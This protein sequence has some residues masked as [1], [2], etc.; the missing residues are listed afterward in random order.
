M[1]IDKKNSPVWYRVV[2]WIVL[3]AFVV[4]M[5]VV[6]VVSIFN[7]GLQNPTNSS[8]TNAS[9]QETTATAAAQKAEATI[10]GRHQPQVTAALAALKSKPDDFTTNS[11]VGTA[12]SLW[13]QDLMNAGD[14]QS[15]I[16][17]M[18]RY[19]DAAPYLAKAYNL[20]PTDTAIANSYILALAY[21]G[22]QAQATSVARDVTK[23]NPNDAQSWSNLGFLLSTSSDKNAKTEAIAALQTAIKKDTSG[24]LKA[25]AQ[26]E[27][28]TL[29]KAQ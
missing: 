17:A 6:G 16:D 21:S 20:K 13:G 8:S 15:S 10:N 22:D 14:N 23:K 28:D 27:I 26:Q 2:V 5:V 29:N 7:G 3:I 1:A 12:Y 4:G 9:S 19:K 11:N 25:A 18:A 24:T